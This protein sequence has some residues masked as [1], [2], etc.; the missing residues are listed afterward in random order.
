MK[1]R[2]NVKPKE[3]DEKLMLEMSEEET[4]HQANTSHY[5]HYPIPP[6]SLP[7]TN[8]SKN[9][10]SFQIHCKSPTFQT[11]RCG[12]GGDAVVNTL[13]RVDI[14]SSESNPCVDRHKRVPK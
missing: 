3:T 14:F 9:S 10:A 1:K 4:H 7:S 5:I 8:T 6:N 2:R 13:S 11:T 12:G